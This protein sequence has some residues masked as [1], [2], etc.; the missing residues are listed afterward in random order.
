MDSGL[1]KKYIGSPCKQEIDPKTANMMADAASLAMRAKK[2]GISGERQ[3]QIDQ[4]NYGTTKEKLYR[5]ESSKKILGHKPDPQN[6][7]GRDWEF[8]T[9][10]IEGDKQR[11]PKYKSKK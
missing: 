9:V 3:M 1:Y 8:E 6:F 5:G 10:V 2:R 7:G 4:E 11:V